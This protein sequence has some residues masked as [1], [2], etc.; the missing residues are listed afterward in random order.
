[1]K[2]P[3]LLNRDPPDWQSQKL[4]LA[5][6]IVKELKEINS[7]LDKLNKVMVCN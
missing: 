2:K 3:K 4:I 1:M 7:K 5:K 6:E